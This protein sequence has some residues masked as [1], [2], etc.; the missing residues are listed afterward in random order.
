MQET[1]VERHSRLLLMVAGHSSKSQAGNPFV[2][3]VLELEQFPNLVIIH[4][5]VVC[6]LNR[7]HDITDAI[8]QQGVELIQLLFRDN[9]GRLDSLWSE[10]CHRVPADT[11]S[12]VRYYFRG[13]RGRRG[14]SVSDAAA[15]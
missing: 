2:R 11:S 12:T 1:R 15:G 3:R 10:I 5:N 13:G 9:D 7:N 8:S 6:A 14:R 4:R